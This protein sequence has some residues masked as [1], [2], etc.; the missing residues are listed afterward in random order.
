M[1]AVRFLS[2]A[3]GASLL[4]GCLGYDVDAVNSVEAVGD[5]FTQ[6]LTVEY[7][8]LANFEANQMGDWRD[9]EY[10]ARKGLATA[11]G[12]VVLPEDLAD[13]MLPADSIDELAEARSRLLAALDGNARASLPVEAAIAQAK[14]DCWVEQQ[15]ENHQ[16]DHIA[17]CRDE[18]YAFLAMIEG[19]RPAQPAEVF[20]V[21]FDF[22]STVITPEA[23]AVLNDVVAQYNATGGGV[24]EVVGYTDRSGSAAYNQALSLRRAAAVEQALV[25]KGV[26]AGQIA[27]SGR[28]ENDPLV[29]T[30]DGVREPSNR[31]AEIEIVVQ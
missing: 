20:F 9:A 10:F 12:E 15:E 25:A 6:Q 18:F 19:P 28:G 21:F 1:K 2:L 4:A 27:T 13:W 24:I 14:F 8:D 7:R 16:A 23:D 26:S 29:E 30:P 3:A 31:R 22:D 5:E 17:A 11:A